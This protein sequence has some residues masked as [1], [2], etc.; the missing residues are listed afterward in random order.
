[1]PADVLQSFPAR[2]LTTARQ[3]LSAQS[4]TPFDRINSWQTAPKALALFLSVVWF[5]VTVRHYKSIV[6]GFS[7]VYR[8]PWFII[9]CDCHGQIVFIIAVYKLRQTDCWFTQTRSALTGPIPTSTYIFRV[10]YFLSRRPTLT[11]CFPALL[12]DLLWLDCRASADTL[13]H[14]KSWSKLVQCSLSRL[15]PGHILSVNLF[16]EGVKFRLTKMTASSFHVP[17]VRMETTQLVYSEISHPRVSR[18]ESPVLLHQCHAF[19]V[20]NLQRIHSTSRLSK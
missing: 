16:T 10:I 13:T 18:W 8:H 6:S 1:M 14:Q 12:W 7:N 4:E 2:G 20:T 15:F 9:S 11:L 3:A 17:T 19:C 5:D